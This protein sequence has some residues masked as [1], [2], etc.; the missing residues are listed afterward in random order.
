MVGDRVVISAVGDY[1]L[2]VVVVVI[3]CGVVFGLDGTVFYL[4]RF[5][6]P[7]GRRKTTK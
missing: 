7:L 6:V 3:Y 1:E 4:W 5:A 2:V